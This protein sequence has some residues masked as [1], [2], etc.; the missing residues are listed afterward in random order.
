VKK[1]LVVVA[2]LLSIVVIA[3]PAIAKG[4]TIRITIDAPNLPSPIEITDPK[5]LDAFNVWTGPGTSSTTAT[6]TSYDSSDG[7]IVRWSEGAVAEPAE[8]LSRYQVSFYTDARPAS[9]SYVVWYCFDSSAKVGYVYLPRKGDNWYRTNVST[10]YHACEGNWFHSRSE[11]DAAAVH[12]LVE[13]R[14]NGVSPD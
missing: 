12:L 1:P 14:H 13:P 11:W 2:V 4:R 6:G 7:F 9:P 3:I 10:I 8:A 5:I